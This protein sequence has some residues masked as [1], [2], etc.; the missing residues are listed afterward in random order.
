[1][2]NDFAMPRSSV[3]TQPSNEV[4]RSHVEAD[5]PLTVR[6]RIDLPSGLQRVI[7]DSIDQK[8]G[9]AMPLILRGTVQFEDADGPRG[10]VDTLCRIKLVLD[11]RPT[12][13]A[14]ERAADPRAA[15][16]RAIAE[17]ARVVERAREQDD[18][19]MRR[20]HRGRGLAKGKPATNPR[21]P[22]NGSSRRGVSSDPGADAG[23]VIGRRVG[24]GPAALQRALARPEKQRR[25]AYL[26]TA[27]PGVSESE[28]RA[29]SGSTARRNT[30]AHPRKSKQVAA[31]E[32]SRTRP[33]RKS[34]RRSATRTKQGTAKERTERGIL[35]APSSQTTVARARAGVPKRR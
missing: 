28:R 15:Y 9:N 33:S 34:T 6:S 13:T 24:H 29:G 5:G 12:V 3:R 31:L 27:A 30:M 21:G 20:R 26:D 2:Q 17:V 1:V 35:Y 22:A 16:D 23:S 7:R 19:A 18:L 4:E 8:L 32:D 11:G 14:E 25:D 10:R